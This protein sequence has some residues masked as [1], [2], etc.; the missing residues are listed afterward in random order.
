ML[1][2]YVILNLLRMKTSKLNNESWT[3]KTPYSYTNVDKRN[4][5]I[6]YIDHSK[7]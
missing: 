2:V 5:I 1:L 7:T 6:I 4:C 3:E